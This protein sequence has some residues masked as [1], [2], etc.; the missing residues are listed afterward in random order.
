MQK[1]ES[2]DVFQHAQHMMDVMVLST[3]GLEDEDIRAL[4]EL[5]EVQSIMGSYSID[6]LADISGSQMVVKVHSLQALTPDDENFINKPKLIE[7]TWPSAPN[8][9]LIDGTELTR[10]RE[11]SMHITSARAC[12]RTDH[13]IQLYM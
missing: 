11:T 4:S 5:E 1:G 6:T 3:L 13:L 9:C 8:E 2:H 10:S 7:G 12:T